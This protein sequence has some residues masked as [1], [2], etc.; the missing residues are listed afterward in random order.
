MAGLVLVSILFVPVSG[1]LIASIKIWRQFEGGHGAAAN[2]QMAMQEIDRR[3]RTA[4][5]VD[6]YSAEQL[7]YLDSSGVKNRIT[8]MQRIRP[9]GQLVFDLVR[10]SITGVSQT[11]VLAEDIGLLRITLVGK[12]AL[13]GEL[14]EIRIE[15]TVDPT[16][17][18]PRRHS[19]RYVWKRA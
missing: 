7:V 10:E 11:E 8:R 3:L 4:T 16:I 5:L 12:T 2:R 17:S 14:L 15:I 13:A 6:S 9:N 18:T 1:I 19:S